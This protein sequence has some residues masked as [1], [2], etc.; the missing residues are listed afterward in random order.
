MPP[1][2]IGV[3]IALIAS[4]GLHYLDWIP[5]PSDGDRAAVFGTLAQV[6]GTMLGFML[7]ALAV[8][9]SITNTELVRRMRSTGHYNELLQNLFCGSL[10]FLFCAVLSLLSL[11]GVSLP[12]FAMAALFGL[13]IAA[14]VE[15]LIIGWQFWLTLRNLNPIPEISSEMP[16]ID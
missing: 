7:T 12:P 13:H 8:I 3:M 15:L 16:K 5:K 9:A 10:L 6:A 1:F 4:A 11:L 2:V 14:L